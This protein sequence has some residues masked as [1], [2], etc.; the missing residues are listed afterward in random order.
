VDHGSRRA[1][2]NELLHTIAAQFAERYGWEVCEPAHMELAEPSIATAFGRC[3]ARGAERVIVHPFFLLPGRH[4]TEDIPRLTA[5]AAQQHPGVEF[6][7]T[8]PLGTHASIL[9]VMHACIEQCVGHAVHGENACELC[10]DTDRCR[11]ER[12]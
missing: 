7:V 5:A 4:W 12:C 6:L 2:S 11:L 10:R 9:D 3:V 1:E 8:A